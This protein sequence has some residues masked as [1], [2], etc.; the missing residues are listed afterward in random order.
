[1]S[2]RRAGAGRE[3]AHD[4]EEGTAIFRSGAAPPATGV[5]REAETL[6]PALLCL[7]RAMGKETREGPVRV[8]GEKGNIEPFI[9]HFGMAWRVISFDFP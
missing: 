3:E 7:M 9:F 4:G 5:G 6:L 8:W 2:S 1:M